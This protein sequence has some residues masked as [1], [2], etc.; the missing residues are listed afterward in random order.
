MELSQESFDH[1]NIA[2]FD[3]DS[4]KYVQLLSPD[5]YSIDNWNFTIP[6]GEVIGKLPIKIRPDGLSPDSVYFLPLKVSAISA[7]ELNP[8]KSDILYCVQIKNRYATQQTATN[9]SM[10]G[11]LDGVIIMGSKRMQPISANKVRIMAGTEAFSSSIATFNKSAIILE[12]DEDNNVH[13]SSYK[14]MV[15]T[16]V[17]DDPNY[18]NIF[19]IEDDGYRTYKTFLLCYSYKVGTATRLIKEELRLEFK[20]K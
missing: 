9:Y 12:V 1:Y 11:V 13:I 7:Y 8:D 14:D 10:V 6:A 4:S 19:K 17:D 5:K 15:V 2:N 16:Q 3:V 18:P 20:E